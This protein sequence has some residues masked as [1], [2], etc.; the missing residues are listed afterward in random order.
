MNLLFPDGPAPITEMTV[1]AVPSSDFDP[2]K[3]LGALQAVSPEEDRLVVF[4]AVAKDLSDPTKMQRWAAHL[5]SAP[6]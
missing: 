5:R 4:R 1:V 3:H 2:T 6:L